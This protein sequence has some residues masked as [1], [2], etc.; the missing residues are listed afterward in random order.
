MV[1]MLDHERASNRPRKCPERERLALPGLIPGAPAPQRA[2][3][4]RRLQPRVS[5]FESS[6]ALRDSPRIRH[7]TIS[8]N[9]IVFSSF[10]MIRLGARADLNSS[11]ILL[12]ALRFGAVD[13]A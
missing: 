8:T 7:S 2:E 6:A 13:K 4:P 5:R 1:T 9:A 11:P 12:H 3:N 10:V